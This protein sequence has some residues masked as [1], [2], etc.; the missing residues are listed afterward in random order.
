M[1]TELWKAFTLAPAAGVSRTGD[2]KG[3][4][5]S[6]TSESHPGQDQADGGGM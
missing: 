4:L 6:R 5:R 1:A 2:T 3:V